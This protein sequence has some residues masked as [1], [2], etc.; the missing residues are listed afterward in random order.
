MLKL[1]GELPVEEDV[2]YFSLP[3]ILKPCYTPHGS[4]DPVAPLQGEGTQIERESVPTVSSFSLKVTNPMGI[5]I[6][7]SPTHV[8]STTD[9]RGLVEVTLKEQAPLDIDKDVVVLIKY[10]KPH[11]PHATVEN[12]QEWANRI[13]CNPAVMLDFFPK[14]PSLQAA[15]VCVYS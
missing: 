8:V 1:V 4:V 2:V 14:F 15:Q 3:T 9:K 5:A 13:L 6:I 7:T 11:T 12:G 10:N